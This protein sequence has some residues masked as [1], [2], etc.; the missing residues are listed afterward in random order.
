MNET[1]SQLIHQPLWST[2]LVAPFDSRI[3]FPFFRTTSGATNWNVEG[4]IPKGNTFFLSRFSIHTLPPW[5]TSTFVQ[6][7]PLARFQFY[8]ASK[9]YIDLP[10]ERV[11]CNGSARWQGFELSERLCIDEQIN[12]AADIDCPL[13]VGE[14]RRPLYL[15][16]MLDG[17]L[18]RPVV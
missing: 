2:V 17:K 15:T 10:V 3:R 14:S 8:V 4:S 7:L 11:V 13:G 5:T 16:L 9:I 18:S 12:F 6:R 1:H